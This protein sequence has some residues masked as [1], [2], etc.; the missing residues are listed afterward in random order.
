MSTLEINPKVSTIFGCKAFGAPSGS[1]LSVIKRALLLPV[2][3][4]GVNRMAAFFPRLWR[5]M[6]D[7]YKMVFWLGAEGG[8]FWADMAAPDGGA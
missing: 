1:A 6:S 3:K 8:Q 4:V 5:Q 2:Q 7:I